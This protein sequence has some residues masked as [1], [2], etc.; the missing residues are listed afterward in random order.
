MKVAGTVKN[1]LFDAYFDHCIGSLSAPCPASDRPESDRLLAE[2]T[3]SQKLLLF[4]LLS[5][6]EADWLA[7][8]ERCL[9]RGIHMMLDVLVP[10][11][12]TEG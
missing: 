10:A 9:R 1:E 3:E 5:G 12:E 6:V 4:R 7:F 8:S 2:L 11:E